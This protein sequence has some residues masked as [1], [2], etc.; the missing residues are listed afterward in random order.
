MTSGAAIVVEM[1]TGTVLYEKNAD[2]SHYPASI[3]KVMTA[4]LALENCDLDEIVTFSEEAVYGNEGDTSHIAREVG[5]EMTLENCLYG[6]MLESANECAWAI[7]E[8]VGGGSMDKSW[9]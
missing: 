5:E 8:H 6:M 9:K 1:E 4:L 3:T 2:T 7:G